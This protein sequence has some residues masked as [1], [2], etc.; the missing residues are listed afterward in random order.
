[1]GLQAVPAYIASA[2]FQHPATLDRNL[3]E[4]IFGGRQ[5]AA[6][7]GQFSVTPGV[8]TRAIQVS[9]GGFHVLGTENAQQGGYFAWSDTADTFLLAAAVGNPRI[10][11]L[12]LRIHDNQYG[13]I[14]GSPGSYFDVV[15]GVAAGAP[16]AR[17]DSDF[18]VGGSFYIP[19]AWARIVDARVNVGDTAIPGGQITSRRGFVRWGG[20]TLCSST[21][22]PTD[23]VLG[24]RI[25]ET[26]TGIQRHWNGSAWIQSVPWSS[27]T[28]LGATTA[29]VTISGI[30]TTLK[31]VRLTCTARQDNASVYQDLLLRVGGDTG[32]NYRYA[33]NYM[34]DTALGGF[35][36]IGS[37]SGRLGFV[38]GS[39]VT[40]G[41]FT[42][43]EAVFQ[44]WNSPHANNL[45]A[46][47]RSGFTGTAGGH[48]LTWHGTMTYHGSNAYTSLTVLPLAGS[49]VT[50]SQFVVEGWE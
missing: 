19:G 7:S 12:L 18:N 39:T 3:I 41:Q 38:C 32:A 25:Y 47:V 14:P 37:T 4:T 6:R 9:P 36:A 34:Q 16:T 20:W 43:A 27:A 29:S 22:R 28:T 17:P 46:A 30:P 40:A 11:T 5:G 45:T 1:M 31:T 24:D 13:S 48:M 49:F 42:T 21:D 15:Q 8:G 2:G 33:G 35:N 50:G 44:G 23:Q 10:D 26:D